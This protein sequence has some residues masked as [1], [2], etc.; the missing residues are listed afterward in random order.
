MNQHST[1]IAQELVRL[2][3]AEVRNQVRGHRQTLA[4]LT[5]RST[6][7]A[8]SRSLQDRAARREPP[9]REPFRGRPP[10]RG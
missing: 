5:L 8:R 9:R 3:Q 6:H 2:R 7:D 4:S 1:S 10:T